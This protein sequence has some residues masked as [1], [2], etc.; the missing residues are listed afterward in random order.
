MRK[1]EAVNLGVV[2]DFVAIMPYDTL[3]DK[4]DVS[5][6]LIRWNLGINLCSR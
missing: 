5:V 6:A 3:L 1:R 2:C 4:V